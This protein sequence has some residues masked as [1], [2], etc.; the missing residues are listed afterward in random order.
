LHEASLAQDLLGIIERAIEGHAVKRVT[1]A[2]LVLGR[3]SAVEPDSLTFAFDVLGKGTPCE[4]AV[5]EIEPVPVAIRCSCGYEGEPD[6]EF[7]GCPRC[8]G[9]AVLVRGREMYLSSID[10]E[11]EGDAP[12]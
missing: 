1:R 11:E 5:L 3:M 10:V 6:G 9:P 2:H 12:D 8:K 4:G 7:L